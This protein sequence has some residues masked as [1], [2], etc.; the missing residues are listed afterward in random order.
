MI[1]STA[2]LL[3]ALAKI[4][5]AVVTP[6]LDGEMQHHSKRGS[7]RHKKD[8]EMQRV[9]F[10]IAHCSVMLLSA[11]INRGKGTDQEENL[12]KELNN[13]YAKLGKHQNLTYL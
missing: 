1:N 9:G 10:I 11:K 13:K 4:E 3:L 12:L 2:R 8:R 5:L 6:I 7:T